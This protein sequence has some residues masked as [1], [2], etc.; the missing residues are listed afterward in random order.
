MRVVTCGA[1]LK[2]PVAL[3]LSIFLFLFFPPIPGCKISV[4]RE[5]LNAVLIA[6]ADTAPDDCHYAVSLSEVHYPFQ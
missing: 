6:T 2:Q 3:T 5:A 4:H 1:Q